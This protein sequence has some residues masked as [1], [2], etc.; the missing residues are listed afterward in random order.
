M[1][2]YNWNCCHFLLIK[3]LISLFTLL[4]ID[5]HWMF[6]IGKQMSFAVIELAGALIWHNHL[7]FKPDGRLFSL[8]NMTHNW[9]KI[10]INLE[11]ECL[12]SFS[13]QN[14]YCA[15]LDLLSWFVDFQSRQFIILSFYFQDQTMHPL[16]YINIKLISLVIVKGHGK[17]EFSLGDSYWT[18]NTCSLLWGK[19][20]GNN[21]LFHSTLTWV[22]NC[23]H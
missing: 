4:K 17:K 11:Q 12:N 14:L 9:R 6:V 21:C 5:H 20:I 13:T 2:L 19:N 22:I 8:F 10:N 7:D 1:C 16:D 23:L 15:S 18:S 3:A